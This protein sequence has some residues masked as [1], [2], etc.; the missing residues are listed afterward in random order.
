MVNIVAM[1]ILRRIA[2]ELADRSTREGETVA[3]GRSG[4]ADSLA[5]GSLAGQFLVAMPSL[6]QT[7]FSRAVIYM[8]AHSDEGAMGLV[9]NHVSEGIRLSSLLVQL[10]VIED[11]SELP[12]GFPDAKVRQGGPVETGRGFVLHSPDYEADGATLS[13]DDHVALT[14]TLDILKAIAAGDGPER[15]MLALGYAGWSAGQLEEEIQSNS[16]L[17]LPGSP[18]LIFGDADTAYDRALAKLGVNAMH[19]VAEAGHA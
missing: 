14:A 19:L 13:I 16:W 4:S 3:T 12:D 5:G 8:C 7:P 15:R 1:D 18:E 2:G 9:V 17:T 6:D 11:R 10:D